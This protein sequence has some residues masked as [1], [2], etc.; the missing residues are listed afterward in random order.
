MLH[1]IRAIT[2]DLDDTLWPFPPIGARIEQVLHDWF[3]T[4][5]PAT[6][7]MFPIVAMREL[8]TRMM[9]LHPQHAN[10]ASLM[11]RLSIAEALRTSG[12]DPALIEPAYAAFYAERN[13]VEFYGDALDALQ[14]IAAHLPVLALT[15]GNADLQRIGIAQ[16]F[17]G[18]VSAREAGAAKPDARIFAH[19][20]DLLSL[21]PE[22]V[23]H[24]GDDI[25]AD[26]AGAQRAG[27]RTCWINRR[28]EHWP[29][30]LPAP[31]FRHSRLTPLADAFDARA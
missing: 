19:A 25:H 8:R 3:E 5:A 15:N 9:A 14:R 13:R 11:R 26:I 23:L 7:R 1:T 2:L 20:C 4:H 6:A 29:D 30:D 18:V 16:H 24:V 22:Q 27:L 21:R 10:D 28:E 31:D 12:A 17:C